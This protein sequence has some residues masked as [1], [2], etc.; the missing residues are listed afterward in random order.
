MA[1]PA[2][3]TSKLKP[4]LEPVFV[5]VVLTAL[6]VASHSS[7]VAEPSPIFAINSP[8]SQCVRMRA[9]CENGELIAHYLRNHPKVTRVYWCGFSD[10]PNYEIAKKQL[11]VS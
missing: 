5:V 9:H 3:S 2:L 10:H 11:R 4:P 8:F 7:E 6:V 1:P